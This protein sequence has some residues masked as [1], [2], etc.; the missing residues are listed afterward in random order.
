MVEERTSSFEQATSLKL[1]GFEEE[2]K[3]AGSNKVE[4]GSGGSID[5][6]KKISKV[7]VDN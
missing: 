1:E 7:A 2:V 5:I 3:K 6:E 4:S